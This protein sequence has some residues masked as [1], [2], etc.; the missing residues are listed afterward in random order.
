MAQKE[1]EQKDTKAQ[2]GGKIQFLGNRKADGQ[3]DLFIEI[4]SAMF[5][6]EYIGPNGKDKTESIQMHV[7]FEFT[8][9][10]EMGYTCMDITIPSYEK[11]GDTAW[12]VV[13]QLA[14]LKVIGFDVYVRICEQRDNCIQVD[15]HNG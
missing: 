15:M 3:K 8:L 5:K 1:E 9:P 2:R 10:T 12:K 14:P 4:L 6:Q 13:T 7:A 11:T